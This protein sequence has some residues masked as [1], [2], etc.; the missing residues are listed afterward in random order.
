MMGKRRSRGANEANAEAGP[1][2]A[3][4]GPV[5][6]MV[7]R[8]AQFGRRGRGSAEAADPLEDWVEL[9]SYRPSFG[10]LLVR[11]GM[12]SDQDVKNALEEGLRTGERLGEVVIRRGWA[13]EERIAKLLADQWQL[14]FVEAGKIAVDPTALQR[15]PLAV[16]RELG[17]L[18]IGLDGTAVVLAVADP[19]EDLFAA[20]KS[21]IG[22]AS[23]VVVARSVLDPLIDDPTRV[24]SYTAEDRI[25]TIEERA[26]IESAAPIEAAEPFEGAAPFEAAEPV[27]PAEPFEAVE[28]F[29]QP[30]L[31]EATVPFEDDVHS[32]RADEETASGDSGAWPVFEEGATLDTTA[33]PA[34]LQEAESPVVEETP[35]F[36]PASGPGDRY[37][38]FGS[39]AFEL[40][41]PT[42]EIPERVPTASDVS[43]V[44]GSIDAATSELRRAR[45]EVES[46]GESLASTR[47]QVI[48]YESALAA[49]AEARERDT[50]MI[51]RLE[52]ELSQRNDVF[53]TLKG[54]IASLTRTLEPGAGDEHAPA[55]PFFG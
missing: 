29:R 12:A 46:L 14:P 32:A 7:D 38:P 25:A 3:A 55:P 50:A 42:D 51:R 10:A 36:E 18:P 35:A 31:V 54:Q 16:A 37:E 40:T 4:T 44:I 27:E 47:A 9:P 20:V 19:S 43:A 52:A 22:E 15:V 17:A 39:P 26:R 21:R 53:E 34:H 8:V 2:A 23:Y 1:P 49:A 24:A 11:A 5:G 33:A 28:L 13:T 45:S 48:E 6:G 30:F 41:P